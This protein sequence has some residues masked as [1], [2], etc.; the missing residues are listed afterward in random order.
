[1]H[2]CPAGNL[3][4]E[5]LSS[6]TCQ[7]RQSWVT[8]PV[9]WCLHCAALIAVA[10]S[11]TAFTFVRVYI[12]AFLWQIKT[13]KQCIH[14]RGGVTLWE[15]GAY[16]APAE[17][18]NAADVWSLD[19]LALLKKNDMAKTLSAIY[20]WKWSKSARIFVIQWLMTAISVW[21]VDWWTTPKKKKMQAKHETWHNSSYVLVTWQEA[22]RTATNRFRPGCVIVTDL[23]NIF[24]GQESHFRGKFKFECF[25]DNL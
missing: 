18:D 24:T 9:L 22:G 4:I 6:G 12:L 14:V 5:P 17:F 23:V 2:I 3:Y 1:M 8:W 21:S 15:V 13:N 20:L 19:F 25:Y 11:E 16:L 7:Q 10:R